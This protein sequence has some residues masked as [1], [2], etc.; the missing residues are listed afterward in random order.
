MQ[1]VSGV[2]VKV[3]NEERKMGRSLPFLH[4]FKTCTSKVFS[5]QKSTALQGNTPYSLFFALGILLVAD[6]SSFKEHFLFK[7]LL[8][9]VTVLRGISPFYGFYGVDLEY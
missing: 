8:T 2:D 7:P 3:R 9:N 1:T 5:K 4:I 6:V